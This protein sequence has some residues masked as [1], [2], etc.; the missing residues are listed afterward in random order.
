VKEADVE[1][2]EDGFKKAMRDYENTAKGKYKTG[3]DPD[4]EH[5]AQQ[6]EKVITESIDRYQTKDMKGFWGKIRWACRKLGDGSDDIQGW[7]GLLPTESHYLSVVAG[8][9]KLILQASELSI[10][11]E[12]GYPC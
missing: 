12:R 9:L 2:E 6:L 11:S 1:S 10:I 5:T 3:I 4:S 7:L 8:G